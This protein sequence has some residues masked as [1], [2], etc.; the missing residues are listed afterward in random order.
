ME[1][2]RYDLIIAGGG[3]AGCACAITASRA[4]GRVLLLEKDMF[5]R[6]KV[7]GEFVSAESLQLLSSLLGSDRFGEKP[8]IS[9]ARLFFER[10]SV[11]LPVSP[12]SASIPRFDLDAALLQ[13]AK[14]SGAVV[15]EQT[16]VTRVGRDADEFHVE[17][18]KGAFRGRALVNATGRWSQLSQQQPPRSKWIGIK[19]HFAEESVAPSVDLYFFPGGYC[20]VQPVG[21]GAVN[22][23][24]MVRADKARTMDEVLRLNPALQ[25][26]SRF[27]RPLFSP[28]TTAPLFFRT[29][30]ALDGDTLLAGDAAGF[31]DPFAGD[32]ISLA[33]H[34]GRLAAESLLPFVRGQASP[35]QALFSY[36]SEYMSRFRPVFRNAALLRR[37]LAAPDF[38]KTSLM[39]I[40][41]IKPLAAAVL[42]N[43][44]VGKL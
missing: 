8:R 13:S 34:S 1:D 41:A 31:V 17:T 30:R 27:W 12:A 6:H 22:A 44:R 23:C 20:G 9:L 15:R 19:A 18:S 2:S 14:Q 25:E 42:R 32:G 40:I 38:L 36:H 39:R 26:R 28:I 29:P 43:T 16:P 7:C 11:L 4:G 21:P 3:P 35:Q 24:A 37:A 5:P 10:K 33:L